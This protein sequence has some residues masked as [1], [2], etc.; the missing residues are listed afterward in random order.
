MDNLPASATIRT[1]HSK[2]YRNPKSPIT[3]TNSTS[4]TMDAL[5]NKSK[6]PLPKSTG[7]IDSV[8][9]RFSWIGWTRAFERRPQSAPLA[10]LTAASASSLKA[11]D[12]STNSSTR[13]TRGRSQDLNMTPNVP[14]ADVRNGIGQQG[15]QTEDC[16][17][18]TSNII[19]NDWDLDDVV[20]KLME[21]PWT[22]RM[23][24]QR[25]MMKPPALKS[26]TTSSGPRPIP[27]LSLKPA[28]AVNNI[29]KPD[30]ELKDIEVLPAISIDKQSNTVTLDTSRI[31]SNRCTSIPQASTQPRRASLNR[32]YLIEALHG[33]PHPPNCRSVA[34][35]APPPRA[36]VDPGKIFEHQVVWELDEDGLNLRRRV[37][38]GDYQHW[39]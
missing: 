32:L 20:G 18:D 28:V 21:N 31:Q 4:P 36:I 33:H 34:P 22:S 27:L 25:V 30:D 37:L 29:R 19:S 13:T 3:N 12:M 1:L 8:F 11:L 14:K 17:N 2:Y 38:R 23:D 9:S 39:R 24:N 7:A 26:K 35:V 15:R 16:N 5:P 6:E 10:R